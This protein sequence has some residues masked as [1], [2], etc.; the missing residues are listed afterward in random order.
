MPAVNP[1]GWH[2][3]LCGLP[4]AVGVV[5]AATGATAATVMPAAGCGTMMGLMVGMTMRAG[6]R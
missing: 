6:G 3:L 1:K 4:I 2:M 5:L